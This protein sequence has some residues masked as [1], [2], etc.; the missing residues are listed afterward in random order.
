MEKFKLQEV[1]F[2]P[3]KTLSKGFRQRVGMAQSLIGNPPV[4][5]FD[6]PSAGLDPQQMFEL[7]TI[8]K[9]LKKD[10]IVILSTHILPEVEQ[11]CDEVVILD[12]GA[13]KAQG[14][15]SEILNKHKNLE[16]FYIRI[17]R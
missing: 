13:V 16:D 5:V 1:I 14:S 4:L 9:D 2:K 15:L 6:E 10:H 12:G 7:R 3:I 8:I 11:V 17:T